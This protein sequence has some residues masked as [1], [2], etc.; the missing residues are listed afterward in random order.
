MLARYRFWRFVVSTCSPH[1][2]CCF[3]RMTYIVSNGLSLVGGTGQLL[4]SGRRM[5][6]FLQERLGCHRL[7]IAAGRLAGAGWPCRQG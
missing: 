6:R 3:L 7:P 2:G 5:Q 4:A 1:L